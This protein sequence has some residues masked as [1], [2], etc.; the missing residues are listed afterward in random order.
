MPLSLSAHCI[1]A[2][3]EAKEAA[4]QATAQE[5]ARQRALAMP[6]AAVP[7]SQKPLTEP[8]D[9]EFQTAKRQR[10]QDAA[11]PD[12]VGS[13]AAGKFSFTQYTHSV[14]HATF[15]RWVCGSST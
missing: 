15:M 12:Q 6:K 14:K 1:Q 8:K 3:K 10:L 9:I 11:V 7:R 2:Q 5:A 13:C 4:A